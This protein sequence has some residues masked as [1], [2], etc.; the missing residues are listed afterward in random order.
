MQSQ[1]EALGNGR[2]NIQGQKTRCDVPV[3]SVR[4]EKKGMNFFFLLLLFSSGPEWIGRCPS[5]LGRTTCFTESTISTTNLNKTPK[6]ILGFS[7]EIEPTGFLS[8]CAPH[9]SI[10]QVSIYLFIHYRN[11]LTGLPTH[12]GENNLLYLVY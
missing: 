3:Q 1:S 2:T 5:I 11:W 4:L 6:S 7:R 8:I 12:S 10:N 9:P